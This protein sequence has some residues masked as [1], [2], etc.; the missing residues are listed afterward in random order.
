MASVRKIVFPVISILFGILLS[1][2]ILEVIFRILPVRDS[3]LPLPVNSSNPVIRFTGNRDVIWSQ[4]PTFSIVT[5]KHV[6]NYGFI[7]DRDYFASENTPLLAII[8]DSYVEAAQVENR[9]SMHGILSQEAGNDVRVYSFGASGSPLSTYLAYANYARNEFNANAFVFIVV[10]NDFDESLIKYKSAPGFHYFSD[11]A[12]GLKL[13]RKDYQPTLLKRLSRRS[14]LIRYLAFNVNL[15]WRSI[16]TM[17]R[18]DTGD[19]DKMFVGNT[20]ADADEV[21]I[22]DSK[23]A[24][25]RFLEELPVQSGVA[26]EK[27]LFVID[28]MRPHL[29][30]P[31]ALQGARGS[32][33]DLM[34]NYFITRARNMG[35]EVVDMQSIFIDK[36]QAEGKQFEFLSDGHWN[37]AGHALVAETI[38]DS[39]VYQRLFVK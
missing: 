30:N 31:S 25:D 4:G 37:E 35:Y 36:H 26:K 39:M 22:S 7:S 28:G 16:E 18:N 34:R 5:R 19:A 32:Y 3:L 29:Y 17:F 8:G 10:G 12:D 13:I 38:K 14:A 20:R 1:I 33:F 2:V 23:R 11:S 9:N 21:R 24:V 6:N 27:I 15:S